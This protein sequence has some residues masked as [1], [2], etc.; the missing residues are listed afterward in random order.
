MRAV[1]IHIPFCN[2]ICSYCDFCK[3]LNYENWTEPYL[4]ALKE[5][6][7]EYYE[8]DKVKTLYIGGGTPS[9]LKEEYI[10]KLF[11]ILKVFKLKENAEITFECNVNDITEEKLITLKKHNV[12]RLSVGVESFNKY[13]LKFLNRKHDKKQIIEKINL[14]KQYGF[15]NINV[16]LIYALPTE[17]MFILMKDISC[18]LKLD[19]EHI[20]TYSLIIE[21]NTALHNKKV[22]NI[23]EELDSKMYKYICKKLKKKN[24]IHYEVSNFAKE[25]KESKHN[26]TYWDNEEYYGFGCGAHGYINN[27]RYENTRSLS[28]YFDKQ[29]RLEEFLVS[30]QEE[31][32]NE[33]ILGLRKLKGISISKFKEKYD[34]DIREVFNINKAIELSYLEQ[35][36]DY[37]FIP[38][39]KIYIMNE[40]I[41]IIM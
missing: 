35:K 2:S 33:V 27:M 28:K 8:G 15:D 12:N 19:V 17:D 16:D 4:K 26:L 20:S 18:L 1:Y 13:N 38:E 30:I 34:K 36:G 41:N 3:F 25:G 6:I 22:K 37:L 24:Y 23:D 14:C 31:M 9:A 5:E 7:N 29:F 40:I 10:D 11:N 21:E 39:D 32:E